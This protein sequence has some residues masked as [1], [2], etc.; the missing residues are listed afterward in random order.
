MGSSRPGVFGGLVDD[1]HR[2]SNGLSPEALCHA[3]VL[4]HGMGAAKK[5]L[6]YIQI[7]KESKRGRERKVGG[8]GVC[9]ADSY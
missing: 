9:P 6:C 7:P 3:S 2:H 8:S 1:V 5:G 4:N